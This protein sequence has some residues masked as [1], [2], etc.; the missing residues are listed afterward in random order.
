MSRRDYAAAYGPTTGDLVRLG[1]TDLLAEIEH[2]YAHHGDELTT[3]AGKAMRDGEGFQTTGTQASGAL[4]SVIQNATILDAVLGIVKG[5]IGI[6]DGR[7]VAIGK[8]GNPDT[9][10]G[11]DPRL[12]C[13]PN[14]T[15]VPCRRLHLMTAGAIEAHAHFISPQQC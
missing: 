4:D 8:A 10:Q 1:D 14:T 12:R 9:M 5:D 2:D 7:I 15:V 6:R 11:V 13:G 3:G